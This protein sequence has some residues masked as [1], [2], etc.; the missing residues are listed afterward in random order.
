MY[1]ILNYRHK[2]LQYI[3]DCFETNIN[4]PKNQ[5]NRLGRDRQWLIRFQTFQ[6][7]EIMYKCFN[8][9]LKPNHENKNNNI[10]VFSIYIQ[11]LMCCIKILCGCRL[12]CH[13][14]VVLMTYEYHMI[15][16]SSPESKS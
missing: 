2:V 10:L 4:E 9:E 3:S 8:F 11:N 1:I 6:E 15:N 13:P 5:K 16:N 14:I 12:Y 7:A